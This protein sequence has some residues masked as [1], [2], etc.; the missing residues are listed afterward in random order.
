MKHFKFLF[1][2][3]LL[4]CSVVTNAYDVIIGG[5]Y[6]NYTATNELE[7]T[8][9]ENPYSG[10]VVIPMNVVVEG[11]TYVVTSIGNSAFEECVDLTS[12][13]VPGSV[14]RIGMHAFNGCDNLSSV[15]IT[16]I[17]AWCNINFNIDPYE[18][19]PVRNS[20]NPLIYADALYLNGE[21][22]TDLVIPDNVTMINRFAFFAYRGLE[23]VEVSNSVTDIGEDAFC[24]C[25]NLKSAKL[26]SSMT[27][28]NQGVFSRTGLTSITIPEGVKTLGTWSFDNCPELTTVVLPSTLNEIG[29]YAFEACTNLSEIA[30]PESLTFI[31]KD[32]FVNT[33]LYNNQTGGVYLS[34]WLLGYNGELAG[35]YVIADGT[36]YI[37]DNVFHNC[38][39]L[40]SIEIPNSVTSIGNYAFDDCTGLKSV[41]MGNGITSIGE[42][43]FYNCSG[44]TSI[45]IP[46][47]V[48]RIGDYAF[49]DCSGLVSV[50]IPNGLTSIE[51]SAFRGCTSLGSIEIP[52]SV[53]S[54]GGHAFYGCSGLV[55]VVIP[56][57]VTS[58]EYYAFSGCSGLTDLTIGNGVASIGGYAFE[59]CSNIAE[60]HIADLAAWC[61]IDYAGYYACPLYYADKLYLNG[62]LVTELVI[63]DGVTEV[64][65]YAFYGFSSLASV[66][67]PNSVTSIGKSVFSG[68]SG[69]T[70]LTIGNGVANIGGYAFE[71]CSNL[72]EVHITDL[73]AWCNIDYA[74]Y[75]ACPSY[76]AD[77]LYLNGELVTELVIPDGVT[78][79]R[80]YAFYGFSSLASVAI[81]NSVTNIG[82][83]VFEDCSSLASVTIPNSVTNIGK[84]VFK[85][86]SGLTNLTIGNGV[87]NIGD[88]A[89]YGCSNLAEVHITDLATWCNIDFESDYSNPI[90]YSNSLYLNGEL[91]TE[92]VIPNG[93]TEIKDY[94]FTQNRA[95]T[96]VVIPNSVVN[97]GDFAFD[98]CTA[99]KELT[100]GNG[101]TSIGE[102]A[103]NCRSLACISSYIPAEKLFEVSCFASTTYRRC[104]LYVPL[105]AKDVYASTSGWNKFVNVV[106]MDFTDV[107]EVKVQRTGEK[108]IYDLYGRK[109]DAPA[110][111]VYIVNG[112]QT[113]FK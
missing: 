69:L 42:R 46:N 17:S 66:A 22:V 77:K 91:V 31:G 79:V 61:N 64:R 1:T 15:Y 41:R 12:I 55:S 58:I 96:S 49:Y 95:L 97:I 20:S 82:E 88:N 30:L 68:C 39:G 6:Y 54:I 84:S 83:R 106:E 19:V 13:E 47:S 62:E 34:G 107:D 24:R 2:F 67:I 75:Y 90:L 32:V 5:V 109:V 56:N 71:G 48:T 50:V 4:L 9:G 26:S 7:V 70:D 80:D 65:D 23:S 78:E 40:T 43:A 103:F 93:V 85:G 25:A 18:S 53:T 44:L 112:K 110:K 98:V 59:G 27:I 87:A 14:K 21:L 60:V 8:Y 101:V 36:K 3:F 52:N 94:A 113:L 105:G 73:A 86:C 35:E 76:Y 51:Y 74:G 108:V 10:S 57:S 104:L 102:N 99:L 11:N 29:N 92:L 72:A 16:D 100:I 45:E 37:A 38:S 28:I 63:P 33:A 81:P 89:F 111:G